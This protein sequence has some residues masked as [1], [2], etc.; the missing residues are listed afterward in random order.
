MDTPQAVATNGIIALTLLTCLTPFVAVALL[1]VW[2][3]PAR[4]PLPIRQVWAH[5]PPDAQKWTLAIITAPLAWLLLGIGLGS[6][7]V[8]PLARWLRTLMP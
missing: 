3:G 5:V 7:L 4:W 1:M 2:L 8:N 6:S